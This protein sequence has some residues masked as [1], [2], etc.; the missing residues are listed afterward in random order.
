MKKTLSR[1]IL[2][3]FATSAVAATVGT[4]QASALSNMTY[5]IGIQ[6]GTLGIGPDFNVGVN[7][8]LGF[9]LGLNTYNRSYSGTQSNVDYNFKAKLN[10]VHLLANV[11]PFGGV[12]HLTA[13]VVSNGNKFDLTG[14]PTGG[15]YTINNQQYTASQVGTLDGKI[16]FPGTAYYVGLGWGLSYDP[17]SH[18]GFNFDLGGLYQGKPKFELTANGSLANGSSA[19]DKKFQSNLAAQQAKTQS[20]I[21]NYRWY[22]VARIG[23]YFKF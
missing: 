14:T 18:W 4:A 7:K 13:G 17:G 10:T 12:F 19:N 9:D 15:T 8:Y 16:T 6:A 1:T 5:G 2:A 20:D 21:N 22:P 3:V 23:A 11:Y